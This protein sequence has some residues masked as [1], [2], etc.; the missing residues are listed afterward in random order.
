MDEIPG[1][2]DF[3][4]KASIAKKNHQI[5]LTSGS[6]DSDQCLSMMFSLVKKKDNVRSMRGNRSPWLRVQ[7][8]KPVSLAP[9]LAP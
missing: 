3:R 4:G 9:M 2:W 1:V 7:T 5:K 6:P 8:V